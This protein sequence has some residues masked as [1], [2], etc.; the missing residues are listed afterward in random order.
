MLILGTLSDRLKI[1]VVQTQQKP[2][3][4]SHS[5]LRWYFWSAGPE[6]LY[7]NN[8]SLRLNRSTAIFDT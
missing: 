2:I 1:H 6:I 5:N 7:G 8:R 3:S 4:R